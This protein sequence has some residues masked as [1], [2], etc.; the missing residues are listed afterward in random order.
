MCSTL[1]CCPNPTPAVS[2]QECV[3][4]MQHELNGA[5]GQSK[6]KGYNLGHSLRTRIIGRKCLSSTCELK[7]LRNAK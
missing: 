2:I 7:G 4:V 3:R 6:G 1:K 5:L